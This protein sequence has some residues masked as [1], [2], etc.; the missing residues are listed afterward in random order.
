MQFSLETM[1]AAGTPVDAPRRASK[2]RGTAADSSAT[3][4]ALVPVTRAASR[5]AEDVQSR[6]AAVEHRQREIV[7]QLGF[8]DADVRE[9]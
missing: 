1:Q 3:H 4:P 5:Q 2:R 9:L 7:K 6:M 8:L